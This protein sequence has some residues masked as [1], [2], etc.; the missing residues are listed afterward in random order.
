[1]TVEAQKM[2][3]QLAFENGQ[4]IVLYELRRDDERKF[5]QEWLAAVR[6]T[7]NEELEAWQGVIADIAVV[8]L[9]HHAIA[10]KIHEKLAAN[11]REAVQHPG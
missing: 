2:D 3:V 11:M 4:P 6:G 8:G 5:V 10:P 7:A 9:S 1:M